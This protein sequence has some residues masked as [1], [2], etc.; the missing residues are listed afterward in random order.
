MGSS[1]DGAKG[2]G[3]ASRARIADLIALGRRV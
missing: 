1:E 3:N 2:R